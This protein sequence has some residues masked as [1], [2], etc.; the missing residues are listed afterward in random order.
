MKERVDAG[1]QVRQRIHLH[2]PTVSQAASATENA[3]VDSQGPALRGW[4][5]SG[6]E[7]N[8]N[9]AQNP[10]SL[11]DENLSTLSVMSSLTRGLL[12]AEHLADL[13]P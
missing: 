8:S 12:D 5:S 9:F 7:A 4:H 3:T 1:G 6:L 10:I 11:S 2:R 13:R